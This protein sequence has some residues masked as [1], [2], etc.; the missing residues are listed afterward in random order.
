MSQIEAVSNAVPVESFEEGYVEADGFRIRYRTTGQGE[1]LVCL[2]GAGGMRISGSHG[3]L[4]Q[5]YRV[6]ALE[7]PGFGES[8]ANDRTTSMQDLAFTMGHAITNLGIDRFHLMGTSFGG[9]LAL[10]LAIQQ[11]ERIQTLTLVS[12]AAIRPEGPSR[13]PITPEDRLGMLYAHPE[14]QPPMPPL[15]PAIAVKQE[16]L[17]QRLMGPPRDEELESRFAELNVPMLVLFGTRDRAIPPEMGRI[18]REK[19]PNCH[20]ILVYDAGHALDADRPEAFASV[21]GDFLQNGPAFV[22]NRQSAL[23]HP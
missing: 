7:A 1:P 19:L 11:P 2:H 18:Y 13:V 9:K 20:F 3:L 10:W 14:R 6:I 21:V 4:A 23:I 12:P 17:V 8:S 16:A 22:V 15:D 5:Q